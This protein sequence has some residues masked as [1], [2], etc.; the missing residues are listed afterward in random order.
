MICLCVCVGG[1]V[2]GDIVVGGGGRKRGGVGMRCSDC[3]AYLC[4]HGSIRSEYS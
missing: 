4:L 2:R 3:T 1:G